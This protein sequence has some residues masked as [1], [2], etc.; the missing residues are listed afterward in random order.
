[1]PASLLGYLNNPT[2]MLT[3]PTLPPNL[4][5][6][7]AAEGFALH[8][9]ELGLLHLDFC[10]GAAR[11][12][13]RPQGLS[14]NVRK[15]L[16]NKKFLV[17]DGTAG[18]GG[19]SCSFLAAGFRVQA[20]EASPAVAWWLQTAIDRA[21]VCAPSLWQ[22]FCGLKNAFYQ[23]VI[24]EISEPFVLYLDEMFPERQKSALN[25]KAMRMLKKLAVTLPPPTWE[26]FSEQ[27]LLQRLI[28]KRPLR[29]SGLLVAPPSYQLLGSAVR[30]DV[31]VFEKKKLS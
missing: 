11:L 22:D 2:A 26:F 4:S 1:M 27:R 25:S 16:G 12:R 9:A 19:D 31:Y 7:H 24:Q 28:I 20:C 14:A 29:A 23:D 30:F 3:P 18:L 21:L 8:D 15:A 5:W 13:Q 17:V 6:Q 10:H